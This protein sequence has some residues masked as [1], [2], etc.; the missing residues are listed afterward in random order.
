MDNNMKLPVKINP[1]EHQ[2]KAATF[3]METYGV[4][5]GGDVDSRPKPSH[6]GVAL[7]AEM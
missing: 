3:A 7:L 6:K 1:Y 5:R 4:T 2:L